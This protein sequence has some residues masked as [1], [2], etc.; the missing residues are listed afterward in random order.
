MG[1][2]VEEAAGRDRDTVLLEEALDEWT[3]IAAVAETGEGDR[4]AGGN[5][6]EIRMRGKEV[7]DESGVWLDE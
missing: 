2:G 1:G 7:G 5:P 6:L 4:G 3:G